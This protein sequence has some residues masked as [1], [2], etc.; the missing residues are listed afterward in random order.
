MKPKPH[1]TKWT[2]VT[3]VKIRRFDT[4]AEAEAEGDKAVERGGRAYVIPPLVAREGRER[5]R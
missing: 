1:L 5:A 4:Q 3:A 2:L